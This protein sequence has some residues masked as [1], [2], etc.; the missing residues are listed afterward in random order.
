MCIHVCEEGVCEG[1]CVREDV[2]EG[3]CIHVCEEGCV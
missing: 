1:V 3:V 2:C